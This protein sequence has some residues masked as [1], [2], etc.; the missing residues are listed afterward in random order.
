VRVEDQIKVLVGLL[1]PV[2]REMLDVVMRTPSRKVV[3][4]CSRRLGKTFFLCILSSITAISRADSQIRYA[5]VTQ[6][7]VKKMIHP[8]MKYIWRRFP[9]DVRPVW[10][11]QDNV[12]RFPNG[13]E[14]HIAGV[15]GGHADD[16]RGTACELALVD[17]ASFVD[18]LEYVVDSVLLPQCMPNPS[19]PRGGK[20]VMASSSPLTPAHDFVEYISEAK[21]N[22]SYSAFDIHS[23]GYAPEIV[24]EFM[25]EAGGPTSTTWR[26]EYLNE[27]IVD[28]DFSIVPEWRDSYIA[29][30]QRPEGYQLLHK[31]EAM[32]IGVRD[33]TALLWGYYDFKRATLVIEREWSISGQGTTTKV[34]AEAITKIEGELGWQ[35]LYRRIADSNNLLLLN[36][37]SSE[38][39]IHFQP[40]NKDSL[41]AMVNEVR[42]MVQAGR[43]HIS[44]EC[45]E[46]IDCLRFGVYQD[47]KRSSFGRSKVLGHYDML[48]A[49]I[50]LVR[51]IDY[52]TNPFPA[53]FKA[54]FN[55]YV[56]PEE[57]NGGAIELAKRIF[58]LGRKVI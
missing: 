47:S 46:L 37:L 8:I 56:P 41:A 31:Y 54:N 17:E 39:N 34:I 13:S 45:T 53:N 28:E 18:E 21:A 12:Y 48:A 14:M 58:N 52:S 40:T 49:L 51:N 16:L 43:L 10:N 1:K 11:S 3:E 4:H 7:A 38:F 25:A 20:L 55:T 27:I 44:P 23:G 42:L 2:Q 30:V 22:G 36:D 9:N 26:R 19:N 24:A 57:S 6:K 35:K 33:K 5:S 50:Y 15:N 32:D 29:P